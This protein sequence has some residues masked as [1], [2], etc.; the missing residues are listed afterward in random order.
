MSTN[1]APTLNLSELPDELDRAAAI[2]M[3]ERDEGINAA[4]RALVGCTYSHCADCGEAIPAERRALGNVKRCIDCA[5]RYEFHL[6]Q[7]G[8]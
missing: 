3:A 6:K 5:E 8:K 1:T 4:R 2:T 7:H